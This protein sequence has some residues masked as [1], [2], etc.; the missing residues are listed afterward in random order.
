MVELVVGLVVLLVLF[1]GILVLGQLSRTQTKT[2]IDARHQAGN[3]AMSDVSPFAGP[4]YIAARTVGGDGVTYSRDDG[5]TL[6]DVAD[7]QDHVVGY[8][9]PDEV[10][11]IVPKNHLSALSDT[12]TPF[13]YLMFGFTHGESS[14]M[15]ALTNTPV[16]RD[17]LYRADTI[18]VKGEAW[19]T[20]TKGI[21]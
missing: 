10:D 11:K 9:H 12:K 6:G 3:Q 7:L 17:A 15:I 18:E 19:L 14:E 5:S 16:V 1:G 21:Y 2:M 8:A 20:W 4:L 13:P